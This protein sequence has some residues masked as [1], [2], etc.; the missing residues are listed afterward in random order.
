MLS[1]ITGTGSVKSGGVDARSFLR[2]PDRTIEPL[3]D[4][5]WADWDEK[6]RILAATQG[7]SLQIIDVESGA[8]R[9]VWSHDLNDPIPVRSPS[10]EWAR[11]W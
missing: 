4:L 10:P 6:G 1:R 8:P 5:S 7:G 2:R 3:P 11:R 9:I